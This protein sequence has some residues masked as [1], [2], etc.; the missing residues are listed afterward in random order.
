MCRLGTGTKAR[1]DCNTSG[2]SGSR[3]Q[4]PVLPVPRLALGSG[5]RIASATDILAVA[6]TAAAASSAAAT[7]SG[8]PPSGRLASGRTSSRL[9]STPKGQS[10]LSA[11]QAASPPVAASPTRG[12]TS[13]NRQPVQ[14]RGSLDLPRQAGLAGKEVRPQGSGGL[15]QAL[16]DFTADAVPF[17][18]RRHGSAD[19]ALSASLDRGQYSVA[20]PTAAPPHR[21]PPTASGGASDC[22][23]TAA[24]DKAPAVKAM[25]AEPASPPEISRYW[26][27]ICR[28]S[29]SYHKNHA[30]HPCLLPGSAHRLVVRTAWCLRFSTSRP[31][32][33]SC[34]HSASDYDS[35]VSSVSDCAASPTKPPPSSSSQS[36]SFPAG[37]HFTGDLDADVE[38]LEALQG[39]WVTLHYT[40]M[41]SSCLRDERKSVPSVCEMSSLCVS[42]DRCGQD[43]CFKRSSYNRGHCRHDIEKE[44]SCKPTLLSEY[45]A[46]SITLC[47]C[48]CF[49]SP[50]GR[51]SYF[52]C[53]HP[54]ICQRPDAIAV[55]SDDASGDGSQPATPRAAPVP[56]TATHRRALQPQPW[57]MQR[58]SEL[59]PML[60]VLDIHRKP[61]PSMAGSEVSYKTVSGFV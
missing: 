12:G 49:C 41:I 4:T 40:C 43:H 48:C 6:T 15:S 9:G 10:A 46:T 2:R 35:D 7:T 21:A 8:C 30:S 19:L 32:L 25:S 11:S 5:G 18:A 36:S 58:G 28:V 16:Q 55:Q 61:S 1:G 13:R 53:L 50:V 42:P 26:L 29:C 39:N 51:V 56:N 22:S 57:S 60:D 44:F 3:P 17:G 47:I 45:M 20:T 37:F 27:A 23:A 24:S 54:I 31:S 14:A 59:V 34:R 52:A 33:H 38:A